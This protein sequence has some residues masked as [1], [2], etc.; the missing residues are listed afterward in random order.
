MHLSSVKA[1]LVKITLDLNSA[2]DRGFPVNQCVL[3]AIEKLIEECMGVRFGNSL[4][5]Q[6]RQE[7][8]FD[9]MN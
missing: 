1:L 2:I 4:R 3:S 8:L 9:L 7:S 6:V 5:F